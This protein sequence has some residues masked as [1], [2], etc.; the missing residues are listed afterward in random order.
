MDGQR[1]L[2]RAGRAGAAAVVLLAV[3]VALCSLAGLDQPSMP[4]A[5]ILAR[6][7]DG[8]RQAAAGIGVPV[9]AVGVALLLWFA[10]GLR[11]VLDRLSGGDLLTHVVVPAAALVGALMVAAV[12]LDVASALAGLADE[13]TPDPDTVRV[14]GM[15][16]QVL[17]LTGLVGG[18]VLVAASTR[19][20]RKAGVLPGW[21]AGLSALV[22]VLC[23]VGFWTAGAASVAFGLWLLGAVAGVLRVAR[24]SPGAAQTPPTR[25]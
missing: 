3:G 9:L 24:A 21:A 16:A 7:Q 12:S 18:A 14:L 23:L 15:A 19:V 6:V 10:A 17:G 13:F 25:R 20:A 22:V 5:S 4:D 8:G 1:D 2:R 11:E